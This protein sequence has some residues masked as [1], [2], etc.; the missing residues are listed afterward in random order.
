MRGLTA[1][2]G[3]AERALLVVGA[4]FLVAIMALVVTDVFLRYVVGRPLT[5]TY[6]LIG[7]YL[8]TGVFFFTLSHAQGHHVHVAVDIL[9][10][11]A[12]QRAR[13]VADVATCLVGGSIFTLIAYAGAGRAYDNYVSGDVLAGII[14][15]PTWVA[16]AMVPLGCGLI[17]LRFAVTAFGHLLTLTTGR[18]PA[19][20]PALNAAGVK[21]HFE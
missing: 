20:L 8:M 18:E 10:S 12:P 9:V 13:I 1:A 14:P 5:F 3:W 21:E 4:A 11:R 16:T 17:V 2:L 6:D 7:V 19:G 15:W